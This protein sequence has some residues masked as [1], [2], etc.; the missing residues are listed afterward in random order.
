MATKNNTNNTM[1]T[2]AN[3]IVCPVCGSQLEVTV[4]HTCNAEPHVIAT[5]NSDDVTYIP[6]TKAQLTIEKMQSAGI[7]TTN[8]FAINL[9]GGNSAVG[10]KDDSGVSIVAE[11]DPI[12][13]MI[14]QDGTVAN[15]NLFRRWI[16]RQ[17]AGMEYIGKQPAGVTKS[18]RWK[19]YEYSI[20]MMTEEFRVQARLW[21]QGD[22]ENFNDR[23]VWFNRD[24]AV[25]VAQDYLQQL[26]AHID[27][28]AVKHCKGVE[29]KRIHRIDIFV[30]D[31]DALVYSPLRRN[32][33]KIA[34]TRSPKALYEAFRDFRKLSFKTSGR[35]YR[36]VVFTCAWE[37]KQ[38]KAFVD[39]YKG[40]G[41]HAAAKNLILF[42]N[43]LVTD[44]Y[45][46]KH[47]NRHDSM[48]CLTA[49]RDMYAKRGEGYKMLGFWKALVE[50][51]GIDFN[52]KLAEWRKAK[53]ERMAAKRA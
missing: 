18:L 52:K 23:N 20:G 43:C 19:G 28:L 5:R 34:N 48:E 42:H 13:M 35:Y 22:T 14:Q 40:V 11:D 46:V 17:L 6:K 37:N 39:A 38:C 31:L 21:E 53:R 50:S 36:D 27:D 26:K 29:Y 24:T 47:T 12:F 44:E 41:G 32:I 25:A 3:N 4:S 45:G 8:F 10:R 7:D 51:N 9:G 30:A 16:L 15:G 49:Y 33:R 1:N 2:V